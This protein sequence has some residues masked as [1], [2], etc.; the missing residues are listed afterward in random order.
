MFQE[1]FL[2]S[3]AKL[4]SNRWTL[5]GLL[6]GNINILPLEAKVL[7]HSCYPPLVQTPHFTWKT[8]FELTYPTWVSMADLGSLPTCASSTALPLAGVQLSLQSLQTSKAVPFT[9]RPNTSNS[10]HIS[11]RPPSYTCAPLIQCHCGTISLPDWVCICP[12]P[13][14]PKQKLE[15]SIQ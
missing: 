9:S 8:T 14:F 10:L 11:P 6:L 3:V 7:E 4:P 1:F 12:C 13:F 2:H 15:K 5:S